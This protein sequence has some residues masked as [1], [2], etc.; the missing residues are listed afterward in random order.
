MRRFSDTPEWNWFSENL[1][2]AESPGLPTETPLVQRTGTLREIRRET[3]CSGRLVQHDGW[4]SGPWNRYTM[5]TSLDAIVFSLKTVCYGWNWSKSLVWWVALKA[6]LVFIF[7]PMHWVTY[8]YVFRNFKPDVFCDMKSCF[9][10]LGQLNW[11]SRLCGLLEK[12]TSAW[13]AGNLTNKGA[14]SN[15]HPV[16]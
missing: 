10:S 11:R 3:S 9:L 8:F 6:T 7:G 14:F 4:W 1:Y 15:L 2:P 5:K 16:H 12:R 13:V